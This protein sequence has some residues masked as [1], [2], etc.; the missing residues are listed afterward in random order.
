MSPFVAGKEIQDVFP[1]EIKKVQGC[2]NGQVGKTF[3]ATVCFIHNVMYFSC[4]LRFMEALMLSLMATRVSIIIRQH[5]QL[6]YY[7]AENE[8]SLLSYYIERFIQCLLPHKPK[9]A[10]PRILAMTLPDHKM[11]ITSLDLSLNEASIHDVEESAYDVLMPLFPTFYGGQRDSGT[12]ARSKNIAHKFSELEDNGE[13]ETELDYEAL[14]EAE[15]AKTEPHLVAEKFVGSL[16]DAF[17][18]D[19]Q[20]NEPP[21]QSLEFRAKSA[22]FYSNMYRRCSS[23]NS[24]SSACDSLTTDDDDENRSNRDFESLQVEQKDKKEEYSSGSDVRL[25]QEEDEEEEAEMEEIE[26]SSVALKSKSKRIVSATKI[27]LKQLKQRRRKLPR[28]AREILS[29]WFESN[30]ADPYPSDDEREEL[31]RLTGL[32]LKQIHHWFTNRRKRDVKWRAKYLFRGRGRRPKNAGKIARAMA[33]AMATKQNKPRTRHGNELRQQR[34][35][36]ISH[37][38]STKPGTRRVSTRCHTGYAAAIPDSVRM[39]TSPNSR[40]SPSALLAKNTSSSRYTLKRRRTQATS[41]LP[42]ATSSCG[43]S[44]KG[45][46]SGGRTYFNLCSQKCC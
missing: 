26:S 28:K 45:G 27:S 36:K 2:Q 38:H 39:T 41:T 37:K 24:L 42:P 11:C 32:S 23:S 3:M 21:P 9:L 7:A 31:L 12:D 16:L 25:K 17:S 4:G 13:E 46:G 1:N 10:L 6:R 29:A 44:F 14:K 33:A 22:C 8:I 30:V 5:S 20:L 18:S 15:Q 34:S 19:Q 35:V 40:G 43:L